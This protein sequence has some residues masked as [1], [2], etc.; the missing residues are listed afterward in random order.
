MCSC[1]VSSGIW[2]APIP[3]TLLE[4]V[5]MLLSGLN[6]LAGGPIAIAAYEL[7]AKVIMNHHC[8]NQCCFDDMLS[9]SVAIPCL[10]VVGGLSTLAWDSGIW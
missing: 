9:V 8:L 7:S 3:D 1:H 10:M 5:F 4:L 6:A 2:C